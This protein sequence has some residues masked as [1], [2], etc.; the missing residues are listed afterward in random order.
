K[1]FSPGT[2]AAMAFLTATDPATIKAIRAGMVGVGYR[3]QR[4]AHGFA[5]RIGLAGPQTKRPPASV[6]RPALK[7]QVIH[8][9]NK[10]MP[11]GLPKRTSRALLD[12]E[13]DA[14][15]PIIRDP[16]KPPENADAVFYFPGCGS[17]RLFSQVGL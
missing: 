11:G 13:D 14:I 8:F 1:P 16:A 6:G 5:K 12:I 10:P 2:A 7:A 17:E 4:L 9:V 3:A 15:V